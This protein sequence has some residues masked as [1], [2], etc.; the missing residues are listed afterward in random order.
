MI[1][2]TIMPAFLSAH[3]FCPCWLDSDIW[4][5]SPDWG[6][7]YILTIFNAFLN[8][9]WFHTLCRVQEEFSEVALHLFLLKSLEI[10]LSS[11]SQAKV[12]SF[13]KSH[14]AC[15]YRKKKKLCPEKI[16]AFSEKHWHLHITLGEFLLALYYMA[17]EG[18]TRDLLS[19]PN[20]L[21]NLWA[22]E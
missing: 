7:C 21:R 1:S 19:L 8:K 17:L 4:L 5:K 14:S 22:V 12:N 9:W 13:E 10:L 15:L 6:G 3:D 2:D 16:K 20:Y 11:L 18:K